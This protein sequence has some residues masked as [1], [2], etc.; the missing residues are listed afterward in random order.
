MN[1]NNQVNAQAVIV[2]LQKEIADKALQIAMLKAQITDLL[3]TKEKIDD[4]TTSSEE[5]EGGN[6]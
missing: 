6:Q 4:S 1:K 5:V 2:E 3:K